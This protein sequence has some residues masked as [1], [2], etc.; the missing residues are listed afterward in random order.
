MWNTAV[1]YGNGHG[2]I[3]TGCYYSCSITKAQFLSEEMIR[4]VLIRFKKRLLNGDYDCKDNILP[5]LTTDEI[6]YI[7]TKSNKAEKAEKRKC[8]RDCKMGLKK[9]IL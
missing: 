3:N 8:A 5:L 7:E 1:L 2:N 6:N 9:Q 4:N